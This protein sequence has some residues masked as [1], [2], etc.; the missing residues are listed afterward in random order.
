MRKKPYDSNVYIYKVTFFTSFFH[1]NIPVNNFDKS[2]I[3][4]FSNRFPNKM[5]TLSNSISEVT[6][7][8]YDSQ[9]DYMQRSLS[10]TTINETINMINRAM[11]QKHNGKLS[12]VHNHIKCSF[13]IMRNRLKNLIQ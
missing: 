4:R 13:L 10:L 8:E 7:V 11:L 5:I 12:T 2:L 3:V 1:F 6:K 9:P